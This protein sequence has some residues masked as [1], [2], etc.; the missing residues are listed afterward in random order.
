ME[1]GSTKDVTKTFVIQ[2]ARTEYVSPPPV[3]ETIT[4]QVLIEPSRSEWKPPAQQIRPNRN[5]FENF[6]S[7]PTIAVAENSVSTFSIDVDTASYSFF[8][9]SVERGQLPPPGAVRLEEMI[10]YFPYDYE[11]PTSLD[12]PFKA[13][14]TVTPTPWNAD[15]KLMYIGIKGYVPPAD[16]NPRSNLVFLIDVSGSMKDNNKLPLLVNSF[17]LLLGTL[18]ANDTV[19]I[20]TYSSTVETALEPTRANKKSEIHAVLNSLKAHGGTAGGAGLQLAYELSLIHI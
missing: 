3:Y 7:N 11:A 20:V 19:S 5:Q 10:N 1:D 8:R 15:T 9:S 14:V 6:E 18:D 12:E 4:E 16:E 17:K 13:N 2:E